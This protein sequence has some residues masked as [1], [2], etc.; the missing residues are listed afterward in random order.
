MSVLALVE[1][2]APHIERE[3]NLVIKSKEEAESLSSKLKKIQGGLQDA[4]RQGVTDNAVKEWLK[5]LEDVA[6]EM[7]DVLDEWEMLNLQV[8]L[9]DANSLL[10]SLC[11]CFKQV[12]GRREITK[13]M[14]ALSDRID[15]LLLPTE[16]GKYKF[17]SGENNRGQEFRQDPSTSIIPKLGV[18]GR[19]A[20]KNNLVRM[21]T[22]EDCDHD[23]DTQIVSIVGIGGV[24]KTTLAQLVYNDAE[25]DGFFKPKGWVSVSE[26]FDASAVARSILE[27]FG[28][29]ST[30]AHDLE[31]LVRRV[32]DFVRDKRF[33]VVLDNVWA[34]ERQKWE[35]L[36]NCLDGAKGSRI[37]VTTRRESVAIMMGTAQSQPL[38]PLSPNECSEILNG[39]ALKGRRK[40]ECEKLRRIGVEIAKKCNGLPLAAKSIGSMLALRCSEEEWRA[41]LESPLWT[42]DDK[43][44]EIFRHLNLSYIDLSPDLKRCFLSIVALPKGALIKVGKMIRI[45]MAYG[46]LS[47][48]SSFDQV[49][50]KGLQYLNNLEMRSFYQKLEESD[51]YIKESAYKMHDI[52]HDFGR[53]L[54]GSE[55]SLIID[56]GAGKDKIL[57]VWNSLGKLRTFCATNISQEDLGLDLLISHLKSVRLLSICYTN[58]ESL[59]EGIGTLIH[60]RY[61]D[62]SD[63]KCIREL[64]ETVSNLYNLQTLDIQGCIKLSSLPEGIGKLM[65]LKHLL[66]TGTDELVE[67]PRGLERLTGLWT[68]CEFRGSAL[69]C[70]GNLNQLQGSLSLVLE[71]MIN[72]SVEEVGKAKLEKKRH[73]KALC[74]IF[75]EGEE[76]IVDAVQPPPNMETLVVQSRS[77]KWLSHWMEKYYSLGNVKEVVFHGDLRCSKVPPMGKLPALEKLIISRCAFKCLNSREF[78]RVVGPRLKKLRFEY[79]YLW[80]EWEDIID[81]SEGAHQ[82]EEL[83]IKE[84]PQLKALPHSLL[85]RYATSLNTVQLHQEL[86][87]HE[88]IIRNHMSNVNWLI[89]DGDVDPQVKQW[90]RALATLFFVQNE[91]V[92]T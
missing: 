75:G 11:S 36:K 64:P 37:L 8:Q 50:L 10:L 90:T 16:R 4:E 58:M 80:E 33:L 69:G 74:L 62:L 65:K 86:Y 77:G 53:H 70:L 91:D 9:E 5:Q 35:D 31:T 7:D 67:Y 30:D 40:E 92:L 46:Y 78:L 17:V 63:N 14:K 48:S 44:S 79:C 83:E 61:L 1:R 76:R 12:L 73:I 68:L 54:L 26:P 45:W 84:C 66:N 32:R 87:D 82:L 18:Y 41:I 23:G 47:S 39:I 3:L 88:I 49:H 60:L 43:V 15:E 28:E 29:K 13:K 22:S 59:H 2:L 20:V 89:N 85:L 57:E 25:V 51:L 27:Q 21:L 34:E 56:G 52:I 81:M 24:G 38:E 42:Y 72:V 6:Y 55:H 19:D 71:D